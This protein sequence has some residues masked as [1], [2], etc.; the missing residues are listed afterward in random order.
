M[1]GGWGIAT[2]LTPIKKEFM[3]ENC[4]GLK[5]PLWASERE[6][7]MGFMPGHVRLM[8]KKDPDPTD[9]GAV[10]LAE[11]AECCALGNSFH[12]QGPLPVWQI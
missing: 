1:E 2:L 8:R 12:I 7:L 11:D 3:V 9:E 10:Q 4:N 5:R 6:I